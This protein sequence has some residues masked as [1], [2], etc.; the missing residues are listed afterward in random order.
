MYEVC[1]PAPCRI[2]ATL[3]CV[4]LSF[5]VVSGLN[6]TSLG[7]PSTW[8]KCVRFASASFDAFSMAS[9][10]FCLRTAPQLVEVAPISLA[11]CSSSTPPF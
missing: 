1:K 4:T 11:N 8:E 9:C 2:R 5:A 3:S 10:Q 7:S 6:S